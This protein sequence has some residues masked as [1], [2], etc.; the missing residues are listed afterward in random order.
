MQI[1]S[2]NYHQMS[3]LLRL[4]Y[5]S[6]RRPAKAQVRLRICTDLPEPSCSHTWSLEVGEGSDQKPDIQPHRMAAHA[7]LKNE[8]TEAKK[9]HNLMRRLRYPHLFFWVSSEAW[10]TEKQ[11]WWVLD[12]NLGIIFHPSPKNI[13][14]LWVFILLFYTFWNFYFSLG[15][16]FEHLTSTYMLR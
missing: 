4:W 9:C 10:E 6:H 5:L 12:D 11:T 2:F 1:L 16:E 15:E 8:F 14:V 7:Y 3:Q 13:T